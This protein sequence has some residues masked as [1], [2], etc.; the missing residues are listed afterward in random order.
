VPALA[1]GE[2]LWS[3]GLTEPQAG[4]DAGATRTAAVLD[5]GEWVI[6]GVKSFI[7]NSGTRLSGGVTITA[8]TGLRSDGKPEISNIIVPSGTP[9]YAVSKEYDKMGW[10]ASDTHEL[11]FADAQVPESNLLGRQGEGFHQFLQTLDGG[12]ISVAALSVGLAQACFDASFTYARERS[13][14]GRPISKFEGIQFK[15]ADM[16]TEIENAR[17]MTYKA[18]WLKDQGRDFRL[19][20]G[21]AKLYAGEV[22]TRCANHAVQ[23]HGGYGIME[24]FPVA[25]YWRDVKIGEIG[26]GTSEIQRMVIA[27]LLGA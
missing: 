26:E 17:L 18:A 10:R 2:M 24:E 22:A 4:S 6:N 23:I 25:R 7:T 13:Q 15:L 1:S 21:M 11:S 19:C 16:A 20:A 14:F 9:G 12:R 5:N 8:V 27:R 3:F